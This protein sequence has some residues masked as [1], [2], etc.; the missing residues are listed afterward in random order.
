MAA[1][2][3]R[4]KFNASSQ[5]SITSNGGLQQFKKEPGEQRETWGET[6]FEDE[7]AEL[8]KPCKCNRTFC[9]D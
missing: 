2:T 5:T 8:Q 3:A 9:Q 6:I 4:C 7:G 1:P